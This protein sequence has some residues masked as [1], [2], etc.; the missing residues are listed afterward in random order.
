ML[1]ALFAAGTSFM[2]AILAPY[3][4]LNVQS[5][6][7]TNDLVL[8]IEERAEGTQEDDRSILLD[9]KEGVEEISLEE[10]LIGVVFA[11]MPATFHEEALKSQA[12]AARTFALR[13]LET[14]KHQSYDICSDFACCQAWMS[15]ENAR[16]MLGERYLSQWQRAKKAVSDTRG[17][18]LTF[19]GKL[20]EAVYF[21]C[22]GGNTEDA[23]AVWGAE[24]PYLQSVK[25]GGEE[26]APVY[27]TE[28]RLS[29]DMFKNKLCEEGVVLKGASDAWVS[30]IEHTDG[31]GVARICIGGQWFSGTQI[32]KLFGLNSSRFSLRVED[33]DIVFQVLGSGHRVGMS[34]YGANAMAN[35]GADY[36]TILQHYY[37]GVTIEHIE[38]RSSP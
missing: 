15:E 5:T 10:Y 23:V 29:F 9:T 25:S 8:I 19:D 27:Q 6:N 38:S 2:I 30:D 35:D 14:Q 31:G 16:E 28:M 33:D 7:L 37:T 1:Q 11:E 20:I 32:R 21:S 3:F 26:K 12:V 34:Q 22:S 36:L 13:R 4:L 18:I 17:E 24:V